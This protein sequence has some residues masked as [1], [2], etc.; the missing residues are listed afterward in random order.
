MNMA[1]RAGTIKRKRRTRDEIEQLDRQIL[2]VLSQDNPQSVRHVFYRMTDPRLPVPVPKTDHGPNNGYRAVQDRIKKLRR[3]GELPYGWIADATR[4]GHH[5]NT[6]ANAGDFLTQMA[7]LYRGDLWA[8]S[9]YYVEVW[10]ESRSIAGVIE[11][12]CRELAVSLYPCG[13]FSSI[14]LAYEAA[15]TINWHCR[16]G[17]LC[18]IY[19]IGDYDPA[20][21]LIDQALQR[22]LQEHLEED[23]AMRFYRLG[24]TEEQ[25]AEYDL[26]TKPRKEADR[27]ALHVRATVEAEAMP[28]NVLRILLRQEIEKWLPPE[29][30]A[31]VKVAEASEREHIRRVA[32]LLKGEGGGE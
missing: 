20:G 30:L 5:T 29:A 8:Q 23:V 31:T 17:K 13:G 18:L 24:V 1:Y 3:S 16:D 19:Y 10:C 32:D 14:T 25:I 22:E 21:V 9:P 15:Q 2:D 4:R 27:R 7:G 26:P 11:H 28:A 6:F 12:T